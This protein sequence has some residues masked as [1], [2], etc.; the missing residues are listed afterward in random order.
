M[1]FERSHR[2]NDPSIPHDTLFDLRFGKIVDE[3]HFYLTY[4][5]GNVIDWTEDGG[6]TF[7]R[8][9]IISDSWDVIT[10]L[11]MYDADI[12]VAML[13]YSIA[14][15][16][17]GWKSYKY[18]DWDGETK[19]DAPLYFLDENTIAVRK[20]RQGGSYSFLQMNITTGEF[21]I[22]FDEGYP[23]DGS[24]QFS[25]YSYDFIN[26]SIGYADGARTHDLPNGS[27]TIQEC[28]FKTTDGG[29]SWKI[30]WE[31][32]EF[33]FLSAQRIAFKIEL[34]GLMIGPAYLL[35]T[36]DGGLSW[37]R[38]HLPPDFGVTTRYW[39]DW[40]GEVPIIANGKFYRY[41]EVNEDLEA[42]YFDRVFNEKYCQEEDS[43][44]LDGIIRHKDGIITNNFFF[45][46]EGVSRHFENNDPDHPLTG[47][48]FHPSLV[49]PGEY[50]VNASVY[51]RGLHSPLVRREDSTFIFVVAE[52]MDKPLINVEG[53][54][55][56][57]Q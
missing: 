8:T 6:E 37:Q 26:D 41:E 25:I 3:N 17:D 24:I 52:P 12:G 32:K 29:Q 45:E 34:H 35:W 30:I 1:I 9:A 18:Y 7:N 38:G 33:N 50:E 42:I 48:Y 47:F 40:A 20:L 39:V 22:L 13:T 11:E 27:Y 5:G 51:N 54:T 36:K 31:A 53:N 19:I 46:G 43:I 57:T 10:E 2:S 21:S 4:K 49:G 23:D 14:V 28:V 56:S 16:F 44:K 55:L 15:T